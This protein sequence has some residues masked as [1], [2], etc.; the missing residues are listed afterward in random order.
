[1][2]E[3]ATPIFKVIQYFGHE[4]PWYVT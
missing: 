3:H 4:R 2:F 1:L